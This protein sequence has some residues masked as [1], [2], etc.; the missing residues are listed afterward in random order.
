MSEF[1]ITF[2]YLTGNCRA[3]LIRDAKSYRL[4]KDHT[5]NN[6]KERERVL[7]CGKWDGLVNH[8][9]K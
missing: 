3:L 6:P 5:P 2:F 8:D 1:V 4:T 9:S 7:A